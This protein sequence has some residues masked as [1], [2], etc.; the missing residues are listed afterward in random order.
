MEFFD[1]IIIIA[2]REVF[3][4]EVFLEL[5]LSDIPFT[6]L[7]YLPKVLPQNGF[8]SIQVEDGNPIFDISL[9]VLDLEIFPHPNKSRFHFFST[10][11]LT[12]EGRWIS[13][14]NSSLELFL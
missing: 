5:F 7:L 10:L 2:V 8:S 11:Y 4:L 13:F 3:F 1:L 9:I 12:I 6:D 14:L